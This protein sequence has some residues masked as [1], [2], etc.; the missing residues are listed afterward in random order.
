MNRTRR[1]AE[2]V[3]QPSGRERDLSG[4]YQRAMA[5]LQ[6]AAQVQVH[7]TV[8]PGRGAQGLPQLVQHGAIRFA[9]A[10]DLRH[11]LGR[12]SRYR[13][14]AIQGIDLALV[15]RGGDFPRGLARLP[16]HV[17]RDR[18]VAV[19]IAADPRPERQRRRV[20]RQAATGGVVQRAIECAQVAR[21][22]VP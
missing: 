17:G 20:E 19:A 1:P 22:R 11:E 4:R 16:G 9:R 14:F 12:R 7:R 2:Y 5:Q 6:R 13:Q 10:A 21:Q 8:G 3:R 15:Q 18:R